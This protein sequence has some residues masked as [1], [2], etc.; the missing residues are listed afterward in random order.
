MPNNFTHLKMSLADLLT[1]L[2]RTR[3]WPYLYGPLIACADVKLEAL[4]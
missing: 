1:I 2:P 3:T 4:M